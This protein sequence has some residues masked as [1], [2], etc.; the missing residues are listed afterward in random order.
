MS[1]QSQQDIDFFF[2]F[3]QARLEF[4]RSHCIDRIEGVILLC[5]YV[6]SLAGYRYG[7]TTGPARFK[8]FLIEDTLYSETWRKVSLILLRQYLEKKELKLY[9]KAIEVL[10]Q[11]GARTSN[12]RDLNYNPDIPLELLLNEFS[13]S[14]SRKEITFFQKDFERFQYSAILW[15]CYRNSSVHESAVGL[16]KAMNLTDQ[17]EP[18]YSNEHSG[19]DG[20]ILDHTRFDIPMQFLVRSIESGLQKL[21]ELANAGQWH[22]EVSVPY[23]DPIYVSQSSADERDNAKIGYPRM[24]TK[25]FRSLLADLGNLLEQAKT[26]HGLFETTGEG[27]HR[28]REGAMSRSAIVTSVFFLE[29]IV[30]S[31][32][33]DFS[34]RE[35]YQLTETLLKRYNLLHQ[36]F[37]RLPLIDRV[38]LVPYICSSNEGNLVSG[39][40]EKRSKEFLSLQELIAIRDGFAHSRPVKRRMTITK[41]SEG[42]YIADDQFKE[43]FWPHTQIPKDI[44]IIEWSNAI[45]AKQIVDWAV[46]QLD[47]FLEG[48]IAQRNWMNDELI[49]FDPNVRS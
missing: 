12:F 32:V 9:A 17:S 31:I 39:F 43:N 5:S 38:F 14:L 23:D 27:I 2:D 19:H 13:K 30:N 18:F 49:E 45:T 20:S 28:W 36:R 42:E 46:E 24:I 21:R 47:R 4:V 37:D 25:P 22:P 10:N 11:L 16:K 48:R 40:F 29:S 41:S 15:N 6:D 35:P 44:F 26:H 34:I 33:K 8:K 3:F 7:G 1:S